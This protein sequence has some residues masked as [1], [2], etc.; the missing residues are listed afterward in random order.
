MSARKPNIVVLGTIVFDIFVKGIFSF[1][2]MGS[3]ISVEKFPYSI[4]GCGANSAMV[5][6][7]LGTKVSL[8]GSIGNDIFATFIKKKLSKCNIESSLLSIEEKLPTSLSILF[9]NEKGER[10]YLH[11]SG[12]NEK[13]TLTDKALLQISSAKIFHIGGAM[14]FPGF[15][16]RPMAAALKFAQQN[17]TLTSVDLGWD[18]SNSWMKKLKPSLQFID[19]LM[20]N[21]AELK[22]LTNKRTL[23]SSINYLHVMG[24]K[25]IVIK[26]G[27]KGAFISKDILKVHIPAIKVKVVDST[28]AGDSFAAGFLFSLIN[29][30][31]LIDSVKFGNTL[32]AL[33][34]K[35]FGSL[36]DR[37]D[38]KQAMKFAKNHYDFDS[39]A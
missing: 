1:P 25:V 39:L 5:L 21:D 6:S 13:I 3:A 9:I 10:S 22:A 23:E 2:K 30:G 27:S 17:N 24:P 18:T 31:N 28:A 36:T 20:M 11:F 16:G 37:I 26:L 33:T 7:Q 32:G 19:I 15:D 29:G 34:V 38:L 14:L 8:I 4:G 35:N 12:A